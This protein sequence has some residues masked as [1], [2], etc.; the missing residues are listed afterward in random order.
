[1][2]FSL[3]MLVNGHAVKQLLCDG[4]L[5]VHVGQWTCREAATV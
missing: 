2:V 5:V 4:V 3:F 1:M